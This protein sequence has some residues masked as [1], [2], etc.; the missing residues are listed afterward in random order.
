MARITI[1][2]LPYVSGSQD[3]AQRITTQLYTFLRN[4]ATQLNALSEGAI[5]SRHAARATV[6]ITGSYRRGD[7]VADSMP[8]EAGAPGSKYVRLGWV[9]V[10]S[11][12]P[13]TWLEMRV[14][15]GN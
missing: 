1:T 6:P 10:A 8:A 13:G 2:E 4:I 14:L 9:C 15:T 11:G 3:Q 12:E 7:Q 5:A